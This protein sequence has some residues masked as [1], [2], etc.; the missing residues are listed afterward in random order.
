MPYNISLY[1]KWKKN[2]FFYKFIIPWIYKQ[3]ATL[4]ARQILVK[5]SQIW[6]I[7]I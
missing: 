4:F 6:T 7:I 2:V 5:S 3:E 1:N